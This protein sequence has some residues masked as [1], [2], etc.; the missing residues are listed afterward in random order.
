L[1][2][3]WG[4]TRRSATQKRITLCARK[5]IKAIAS[6]K[7]KKNIYFFVVILKNNLKMTFPYFFKIK[8]RV[9][10]YVE[11][12]SRIWPAKSRKKKKE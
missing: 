3:N 1:I 4:G 6:T 11:V 10:R 9:H 5:N 7:T 2:E 12:I 8:K